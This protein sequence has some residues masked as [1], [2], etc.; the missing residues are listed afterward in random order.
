MQTKTF[1]G[2]VHPP[3]YK[4]L[5]S[6]NAIEDLP[7]PDKVRIPLA[8]HI[9]APCEAVVEKGDEVDMGQMIG[10]SEAFVS[11]P[12]HA[13]VSGVVE[14]IEKVL[15]PDGSRVDAVVIASDGED[16][17]SDDI[18]PADGLEGMDADDIREAVQKAGI[19]GMGGAAFP[20]HVKYAPPPDGEIDT[21]ILNGCE[22]EPFLTCDHRIMVEQPEK[23]ILGLKII[24]KACDA[25][26]G[27]I[28]V[29]NNKPDAI[30][31]LSSALSGESNL[32]VQPVETKYPEGA[33]KHLID[34]I[35]KREV[36]SGG[37]P[38]DIG[39]VV[40][41]VGTAVAVAEAVTGGIP[42]IQRVVTVTGDVVRKPKNLRV[43]IGTPARELFEAA[44]GF[45]KPP[46]RL[47]SGGPMMGQAIYDL[48]IPITKG[49]SGLVALSDELAPVEEEGPCIRCGRCV[50]AC[51]MG[52]MPLYIAEYPE[53][54][55][56]EYRPLD[57]IECGSCAYVCPANRP[58]LQR[59]RLAKAEAEAQRRE[60]S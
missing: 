35:L 7:A 32:Q 25:E 45:N 51:P 18:Q 53:E 4:E 1:S 46:A 8:Q 30:E 54:T 49:T 20:T 21:I 10:E 29:E 22:C 48:D 34:A 33:E 42:L 36:P 50:D 12:I 52:L 39:V 2:G 47:I 13:S 31:T 3:Y 60:E 44:E 17:L 55:A 27:I 38:L 16:R 43:R 41:N 5:S 57:C 59:I 26:R 28:G 23:V 11:A 40:N 9:G 37:L 14:G 24:V 15:M 19:V 6:S 56:L 58:L